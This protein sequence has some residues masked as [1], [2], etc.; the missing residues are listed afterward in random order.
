[1]AAAAAEGKPV[2]LH[3]CLPRY[4]SLAEAYQRKLNGTAC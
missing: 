2:V 3:T 1:V 4:M